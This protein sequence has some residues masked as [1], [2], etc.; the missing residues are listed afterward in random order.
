[1]K[2]IFIVFFALVLLMPCPGHARQTAYTISGVVKDKNGETLPGANVLLSGYQNGAVADNDGKYVISNLR[3]G[4]YDVL[5]QMIGYL[6]ASVNVIVNDKSVVSDIVMTENVK[7]LKEVVIRPDPNRER[8]LR[9]FKESFVGIS[10]NA[11]KTEI[12]NPDVVNFEYDGDT[13]TL[14]ATA[15]EFILLENKVLG[16]R[17][18]YLLR[19]FERDER[20]SYIRYYGYPSFEDMAKSKSKARQY[21]EKRD[22][23]YMGSAQHFFTSLFENSAKANGFV[24]HKMEGR[25]NPRRL[26]DSLLNKKIHFFNM[27][28]ARGAESIPHRED[29]LRYYNQMKAAPDSVDMLNRA[30]VLTDTLVKKEVSNL[31]WVNY[32]DKL[33]V[34]YTGEKESKAY[35]EQSGYKVNRP[36]DLAKSQVSIVH[37]LKTPIAFYQSGLVFDPGSLLFEGYWGYEKVADMVPVDYIP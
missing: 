29:S 19:Y 23:A 7:Q 26:P 18:K 16:Y 15:D 24:I 6:P 4:N 32:T 30:E 13:R 14:R 17:I 12:L 8:Y 27:A 31:R 33:Y 35:S 20:L 34:I 37:Q 5:V 9:I 21:K 25:P 36:P 3:P 11:A 2:V 28:A 10:P 22:V 1:M